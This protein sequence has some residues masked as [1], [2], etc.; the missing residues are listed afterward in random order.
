M[1]HWSPRGKLDP[2]TFI[3]RMEETRTSFSGNIRLI[4]IIS[5]SRATGMVHR[6]KLLEFLLENP[7]PPAG[8]EKLVDP[9]VF[10]QPIS[11][12]P[13]RLLFSFFYGR[14]GNGRRIF[15]LKAIFLFFFL[16]IS[17]LTLNSF[18]IIQNVWFREENGNY[19]DETR[20]RA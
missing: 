3:Q 10:I 15:I 6:W 11:F 8:N 16:Y 12:L 4:K 13:Y 5:R 9:N 1:E 19:T 17:L 2:L 20:I 18:L 14:G 7:V